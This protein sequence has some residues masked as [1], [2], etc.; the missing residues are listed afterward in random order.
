M[1][2]NGNNLVALDTYEYLNISGDVNAAVESG[3][4]NMGYSANEPV[5]WAV[6]ETYQLLNHGVATAVTVD[7]A[8]CHDSFDI[9]SD[10]EL[11]RLGYKLKGPKNQICAQCHR[12][13]SEAV[14][15]VCT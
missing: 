8:K 10:N 4:I 12:E 9:N 1:I 2:S 15:Q 13:K 5:E 6:T 11:N 14:T 7:C 3:L